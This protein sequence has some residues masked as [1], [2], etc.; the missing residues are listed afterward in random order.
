MKTILALLL[1]TSVVAAHEWYDP[2][3]CNKNDCG[4]A[5]G[6]KV[7]WE[8]NKLIV[9][10]GAWMVGLD[11]KPRQVLFERAFN[12]K[13]VKDSMDGQVHICVTNGGYARCVYYGVGG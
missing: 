3:C 1:M 12:A 13:D 6:A 11:G 9:P 5:K 4:P 8:G 7:K 10:R 2:I